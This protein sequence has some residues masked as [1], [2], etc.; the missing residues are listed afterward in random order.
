MK[1]PFP[2]GFAGAEDLP[3]TNSSLENCFLDENG[4]V[5]ARPGIEDL[6]D[7]GR[8]A[9][10]Q[11]EWDEN[12]YQV[13]ST[14]LI[15]ITNTTTGSFEEAGTIIGSSEVRTAVGFVNAVIVVRGGNIYTLGKDTA[16]TSISSVGAGSSGSVFNHAGTNPSIGNTVTLT[17]FSVNTNYNVSD[18]AVT[19]IF[20]A[21]TSTAISAVA[22][23]VANPGTASFTHAGTSPGLGQEVTLSGFAPEITYNAT[24]NVTATTATTFEVSTIAFTATDTGN[25]VAT[26]AFELSTVVFGTNET[27]G[28]FAI[29]LALISANANFVPCDDVTHIN[30]RFVYIPTSGDPAFFSDIGQAGVVQVLSFFD[31]EELPDL[32]NGCFNLRNTLYITGTDSIELFRDTGASPNPFIRV[33]G[34]RIDYGFIGGLMEFQDTFLFLGR[35]K[36]HQPGIFAVGSGTA[37]KISNARIDLLLST[38]TPQELFQA[39]P[40]R[41]IWRGYDLATFTLRRDSF[42]YLNGNWFVLDTILD[43]TSRPW[44]AGFITEFNGEYFSTDEFKI[45]K[46]E[47][48]NTDYNNPTTKLLQMVLRQDRDR[49]FSVQSITIGISQGFN[50]ITN[51]TV[52]LSLSR[53]GVQYGPE[54]FRDLGNLGQYET[55]LVWNSAGGLGMF[56]GFV[57]IKISTQADIDFSADSLIVEV[58]NG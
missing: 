24:G 44:Q 9:R 10:G 33:A 53:N 20:N 37:P 8:V 25:F 4:N 13:A 48:I 6:N 29:I 40:G 16:T 14:D 19:L 56:Q 2:T 52:A 58:R 27:D 46:F 22:D 49:W 12:L 42:G 21:I 43:G 50:T 54:V 18:E 15:R 38:Y 51:G 7:T 28:F 32:N 57:G 26:D 30:G 1:I 47:K 3:H 31:A 23:S 45:G 17:S 55:K 41:I 35:P 5:L 36:D 34:S 39:R 11:F